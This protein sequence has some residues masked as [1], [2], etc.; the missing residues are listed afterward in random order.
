MIKQKIR[1][2]FSDPL[3]KN[4]NNMTQIGFKPIFM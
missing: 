3:N 4:I 2:I 1:H